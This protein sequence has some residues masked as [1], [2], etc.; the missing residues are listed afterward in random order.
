MNEETRTI[1][2]YYGRYEWQD[3]DM[4]EFSPYK[5][6]SSNFIPYGKTE[7]SVSIIVPSEQKQT[8]A[9]INLLEKQKK[10]I[11]AEQQQKVKILDE[12][13]QSLMALPQGDSDG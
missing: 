5:I 12:K 2:L 4:I 1:V 6:T 7:V 3:K 8:L 13:I 11:I 9:Q 10:E